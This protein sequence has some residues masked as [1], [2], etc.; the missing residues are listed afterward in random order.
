MFDGPGSFFRLLALGLLLPQTRAFIAGT[1][2]AHPPCG[3]P[4]PSARRI[5][6]VRAVVLADEVVAPASPDEPPG[7]GQPQLLAGILRAGLQR[8]ADDRRRVDELVTHFEY[9][10]AVDVPAEG[11]R[12]SG[13]GEVKR[14]L[15]ALFADNEV[16]TIEVDSDGASVLLSLRDSTDRRRTLRLLATGR[17]G[18]SRGGG[19][20]HGPKIAEVVVHELLDGPAARAESVFGGGGAVV[21][22]ELLRPKWETFDGRV[23]QQIWP[24]TDLFAR[25]NL[26]LKEKLELTTGRLIMVV[27]S[28]V[29]E[30]YG[31]KM[32]EWAESVDLQLELIVAHANEDRKSLATFT[33]LLDE[34]KRA[35]PLR[36][37]EPVLCEARPAWSVMIY[38]SVL[39]RHGRDSSLSKASIAVMNARGSPGV[40][41][42]TAGFACACWRRGIPWC[43]LPT[44]LLGIVDASNG[45]GHFYSPLHTFIDTSFLDTVSRPDIRS[46]CGEIMKAAIIHDAR[47]YELLDAHGEEMIAANFRGSPEA[48][49]ARDEIVVHR[50]GLLRA[51][52]PAGIGQCEYVDEIDD[53]EIDAAFARLTAF[54]TEHADTVWDISKSFAAE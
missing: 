3:G 1:S 48:R 17:G 40:L 44:T 10:G 32:E 28:A 45:V 54:T 39:R 42:D 53:G 24:D 49:R 20:R 50:D 23:R 35:D 6:A 22:E 33:F 51:P 2:A 46:G 18:A 27:D 8:A 52:L 31:P 14:L 15:T 36:R 19:A 38:D 21:S 13:Q 26:F 34:L 4:P 29:M 47:L 5:A 30:L 43:R 16:G 12:A 25:G 7:A 9:D 37:S 11:R 41:T